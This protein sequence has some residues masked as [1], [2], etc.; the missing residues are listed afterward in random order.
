MGKSLKGFK[1][2]NYTLFLNEWRSGVWEAEKTSKKKKKGRS[3]RKVVLL[4]HNYNNNSY[5]QVFV[6]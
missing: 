1:Q 6:Y 5:M 2:R 3:D 4:T